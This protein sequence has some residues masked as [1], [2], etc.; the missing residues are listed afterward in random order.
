MFRI[1][2]KTKLALALGGLLMGVACNDFFERDLSG[3]DVTLISPAN[4]YTTTVFTQQFSWNEVKGASRY[5]LQIAR[6]SFAALQA[7]AADTLLGGTSFAYTLAPGYYE[8]RVKALNNSSESNYSA[9]HSLHIDTTSDL[10]AQQVLLVA[11]AQNFDSRSGTPLFTWQPISIAS[12]YHIIIKSGT[13]WSTGSTIISDTVSTTFYNVSAA[14]ALGEGQYTWGVRAINAISYTQN[15]ATRSINIDLTAPPT[16]TALSP[17]N[18]TIHSPGTFTFTWNRPVDQG[19]YRAA[20]FDSLYIYTDSLYQNLYG[21]YE[22]TGLS[23]SESINNQGT[24]YWFLVGFDRAGNQS[25]KSTRFYF[26]V[27]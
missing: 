22:E 17:L 26:T 11:P 8:W 7:Y 10:S 13:S 15:F 23:R 24:Y 27:Q 25:A 2:S 9:V 19:I 20:R 6:P 14:Q 12:G 4:G 21:K 5:R 3:E 16:P 1:F 18:N